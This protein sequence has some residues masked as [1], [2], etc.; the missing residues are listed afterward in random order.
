MTRLLLA[1]TLV[2]ICDCCLA[3]DAVD[4]GEELKAAAIAKWEADIEAAMQ[5]KA[6]AGKADNRQLVKQLFADIKNLKAELLKAKARTPEE[7]VAEEERKARLAEAEAERI[8]KDKAD[9]E[10][11]DAERMRLSGGCPL[12]ILK[13]TFFH[14]DSEAA[15]LGR[16]MRI[17]SPEIKGDSTVIMWSIENRSN[18]PVEA[19]EVLV[20]FLNG[21]DEVIHTQVFQGTRLDPSRTHDSMNGVFEIATAVQVRIYAKRAKMINGDIWEKMP[22]HKQ[23]GILLKKSEGVPKVRAGN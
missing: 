20:E 2:A 13:G 15:R 16:S 12:K 5:R 6:E 3:A 22:E 23:I 18:I 8:A 14:V 7:C 4:Q 9:K 10:A 11:A 19:Y 1:L 21:F 17:L